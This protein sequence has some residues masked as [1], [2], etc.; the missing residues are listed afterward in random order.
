MTFAD[1]VVD[2]NQKVLKIDQRPIGLLPDAEQKITLK[3]LR[4]EIDE[5]EEAIQ[6]GD[7]IGCIDAL[8]DLKYFATG[9][10]YKMG[11]MADTIDQCEEA[12]HSA[13]ME[14]KLGVNARR[15]D[16]SAA[17]AVKPET[18]VPPEERISEILD[19]Q[20]VRTEENED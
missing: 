9:G 18:W 16:G 11:L 7:I 10:M 8:I 5:L 20:D 12:V 2:F 17:D 14:K 4:E 1:N 19:L 3:C 15:G 13:N 6:K